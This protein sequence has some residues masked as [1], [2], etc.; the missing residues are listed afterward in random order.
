MPAT[1]GQ[2]SAGD[3]ALDRIQDLADL[4]ATE[5]AERMPD[6]CAIAAWAREL[7]AGAEAC[8]GRT[9]PPATTN[10]QP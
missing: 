10:E 2:P 4:L 5:I 6:W 3:E 8:C 1:P 9:G 7:A